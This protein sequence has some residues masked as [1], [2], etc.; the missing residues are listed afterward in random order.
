MDYYIYN[1]FS[2]TFRATIKKALKK[3]GS[4]DKDFVWQKIWGDQFSRNPRLA[5]DI[6][7]PVVIMENTYFDNPV[8][9]LPESHDLV[10]QVI[11][12]NF[13]GVLTALNPTDNIFSVAIP[14]E[15]KFNHQII[16]GIFVCYSTKNDFENLYLSS[17]NAKYNL[18]LSTETIWIN[19]NSEPILTIAYKDPN[20]TE[21][22]VITSPIS[23]FSNVLSAISHEDYNKLAGFSD[24]P[25]SADLS[26]Q[27]RKTQYE[28]VKFC[29]GFIV[30]ISAHPDCLIDI[31]NIKY[32]G[33]TKQ[34]SKVTIKRIKQFFPRGKVRPHYR[35]LRDSRYYKNEWSSW[36]PG[37][38]W[39]PVNMNTV[40]V[41]EES[42]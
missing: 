28:V 12:T 5:Y 9:L 26:E 36:P 3:S 14:K 2:N 29:L 24:E 16:E 40:M 42:Q 38:R 11:E 33:L 27:E 1:P 7:T 37:S 8:C 30:Y 18:S 22:I 19:T 13:E 15:T 21:L 25:I 6:A 34:T 41:Q 39:V 23:K 4:Y 20:S 35:N 31:N 17:F 32:P 10:S